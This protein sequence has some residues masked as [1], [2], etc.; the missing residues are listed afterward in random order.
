MQAQSRSYRLGPVGILLLAVALALLVLL[1]A[2]R[3]A[4]AQEPAS[5]AHAEPLWGA[6]YWANMDL[7]GLPV[8]ERTE[9]C[10]DYDWGSDS[11]DPRLPPD[12]FSARWTRYLDLAAGVYRF[13]A[14]SDDGIRIYID[15]QLI[16]DHWYDH[17]QQTYVTDVELAAGR[18]LLRVEYYE[19]EGV[20][21]VRVRWQPLEEI[22]AGRWRG[23]YFD[24]RQL[25]DEPVFPVR[26]NADNYAPWQCPPS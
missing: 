9:S 23:E 21:M 11:P 17:A 1:L 24:N 13:T 10:V 22:C 15:E 18:H 5:P 25:K 19:H 3:R 6:A 4:A 26:P 12:G 16:L 8:L 2:S 14:A 7:S 20:A